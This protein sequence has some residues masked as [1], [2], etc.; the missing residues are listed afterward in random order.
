MFQKEAFTNFVPE[1]SENI[2][3]CV[4]SRTHEYFYPERYDRCN[5]GTDSQTKITSKKLRKVVRGKTQIF[6]D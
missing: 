5:T 2:S 4:R 1:I 6:V 3:F